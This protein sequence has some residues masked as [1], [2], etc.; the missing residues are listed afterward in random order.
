MSIDPAF[1]AK[2]VAALL[3]GDYKQTAGHLRDSAG[4]CCLGVACDISGQG[5][6][7]LTGSSGIQG[8]RVDSCFRS[9][10]APFT[11]AEAYGFDGYQSRL[12]NMNDNGKSF[13]EIAKYIQENL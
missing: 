6:W 13:A 11:L 12:S 10:V 3:S 4:F 2:W 9:A 5:T 7:E 8:Y 1:K